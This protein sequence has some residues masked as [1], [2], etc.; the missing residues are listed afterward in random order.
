ME[1]LNTDTM[2]MRMAGVTRWSDAPAQIAL[3]RQLLPEFFSSDSRFDQ[4]VGFG[5]VGL[6][7]F[8]RWLDGL[9][10]H[11]F[12]SSLDGFRRF[13]FFSGG[14]LWFNGNP[15]AEPAVDFL[16][17]LHQPL[18]SGQAGEPRW[19]R[20]TDR[21]RGA[22]IEAR[23]GCQRLVAVRRHFLAD[24]AE[25]GQVIAQ[26]LQFDGG[27]A[28]VR[29]RDAAGEQIGVIGEDVDALAATGNGNVKLFAVDGAER[30]RRGDQ[31]HVIH[32]L[33]LG[34]V[35]RDGVAVGEGVEIGRVA[36]GHRP[37]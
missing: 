15:L 16:D 25:F 28:L 13:D 9:G 11:D 17:H 24:E 8:L 4:L 32:G 31:Q 21:P 6:P 19:T 35:R 22:K 14:L 36:P 29:I 18:N 34:R 30:A 7:N 26:A 37:A 12:F 5:G 1:R 10:L 3:F 23:R 20:R 27:L 2:R 33:A